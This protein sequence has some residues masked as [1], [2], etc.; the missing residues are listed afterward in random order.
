MADA[1]EVPHQQCYRGAPTPTRRPLLQGSLG[2]GKALLFHDLLGQQDY[3]AVEEQEPGQLVPTY[4]PEL[5]SKPGLDL[6]GHAPISTL[7]RLGA[8]ALEVAVGGVA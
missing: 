5:L 3:L 2:V 7:R 4:Q 1:N 6:R 8:E